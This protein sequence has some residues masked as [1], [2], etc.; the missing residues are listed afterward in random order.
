MSLVRS[1]RLCLSLIVLSFMISRCVYYWMGVRFEVAPL[2]FYWQIIDPVLLR[3]D[4]WRSLFYLRSQV[5]GFN[6]YV[7]ATMHL[8]PKY[9]LTVFHATYLLLGVSLGICLF[10]LLE[11]LR[12]NRAIAL[13]IAVVCMINPI[14][15]LY[16]N[17]LFYE[18][19]IAVFFCISALFLNRYATA[20]RGIDGVALFASLACIALL[21]VIYHPLWFWT[22]AAVLVYV[23]PLCRR[24]TI[25]CAVAPG[26]ILIAIYLKS[27]VL[28]GL[29]VPGSDVHGSLN[30]VNMVAYS[31]T[32][33]DLH[34]LAARGTISPIL[35]SLPRF[36]DPSL[37]QVV[38][39][40]PKTGIRILDER[41]KSTGGINMDSLWMAAV[42]QQLR[43]DGVVLV[44]SQ[45]DAILTTLALNAT[46]S[47]LPADVG[48]P[49]D[50]T[51]P[52]NGRMLAPLLAVYDLVLT[53]KRPTSDNAFVSWFTI[54]C[55]LWFGFRYSAR[56][57]MRSIRRPRASPRDLTIAF[58]F[59]NIA[60]LGA[61]VVLTVYMD[62]NRYLFEVFPLF[63][64]LLGALL[65]HAWRFPIWR[66]RK[67]W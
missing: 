10:F 16:E 62:Q 31:L 23:L 38:P 61:V 37:L 22:I 56:W 4:L 6:L 44:R 33:A 43:R 60:Y 20:Q 42:G 19:P 66:M 21:R 30:F 51:E 39:M 49:F 50:H 24:R 28:F 52:P 26:A 64:I 53:G 48:W 17:W 9:F 47:F 54:A 7:G 1:R 35:L 67:P 32:P 55:L 11:R 12:L 25:L 36:E 65:V 13:L 59:G 58:A 41:L 18:Y 46:R 8:T 34:G 5:P 27:L 2:T 29:C 15:V 45:P 40:P 3:D 14:T 63:A 57:F